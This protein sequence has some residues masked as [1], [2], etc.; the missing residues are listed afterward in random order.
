MVLSRSRILALIAREMVYV[1]ACFCYSNMLL[2][3]Y[4][5]NSA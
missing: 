2:A 1:G 4:V 5:A 3:E